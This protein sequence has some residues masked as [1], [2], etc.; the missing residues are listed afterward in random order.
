M[1]PTKQQ[2]KEI[3]ARLIPNDGLSSTEG[4]GPERIIEVLRNL[5]RSLRKKQRAMRTRQEL[6]QQPKPLAEEA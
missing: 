1:T 2:L 3:R 5:D 6:H 4:P